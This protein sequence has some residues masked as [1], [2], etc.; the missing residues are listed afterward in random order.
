MGSYLI[1]FQQCKSAGR[2]ESFS[3]SAIALPARG[4]PA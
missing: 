2:L 4:K 3:S 1:E